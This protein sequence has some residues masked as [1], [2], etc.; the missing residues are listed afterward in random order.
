MTQRKPAQKKQAAKTTEVELLKAE[1]GK[2][3]SDY[4]GLCS[5]CGKEFNLS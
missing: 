5:K 3:K 2:L 4:A 1:I